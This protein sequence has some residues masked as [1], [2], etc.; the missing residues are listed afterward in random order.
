MRGGMTSSVKSLCCAVLS[1][2]LLAMPAVRAAEPLKAIV[3][4]Y[5]EIHAQLIVDK[6][7]G[8]KA[9]A[10]AIAKQAEAMGA[11]GA[12]IG[13]AA[14]AVGAAADLKGARDASVP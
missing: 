13:K 5:L 8:V 2:A 7:D 14:A 10:A 11:K 12:A 3:G 1:A 4:S 6:T 9:P